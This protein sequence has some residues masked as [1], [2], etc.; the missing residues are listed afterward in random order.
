M[1]IRCL[2]HLNDRAAWLAFCQREVSYCYTAQPEAL[3]DFQTSY[4]L[5]TLL[6]KRT[7]NGKQAVKFS[8]GSKTSMQPAWNF[9]KACDFNLQRM[10]DGL[11]QVDFNGNVR[12]NS[13]LKAHTDLTVRKFFSKERS[14][15]S[16]S[17]VGQL[18]PV[19]TEPEF[20]DLHLCCRLLANKQFTDLRTE[21]SAL[22]DNSEF[23]VE[24][25][26]IPTPTTESILIAMIDKPDN[27]QINRHPND[28]QRLII[29]RDNTP[30]YS[31][32][33]QYQP[34]TPRLTQRVPRWSLSRR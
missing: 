21:Q 14:V 19:L 3:V 13:L 23:M 24:F 25:K 4:L 27:W 20:W 17:H 15:I 32:K 22:P 9:I 10:T 34:I 33:A 8:V 11:N 31:L 26:D 29:S 16:P 6:E 18:T 7:R 12:D 30:L 1:N 28:S 5:I 2:P